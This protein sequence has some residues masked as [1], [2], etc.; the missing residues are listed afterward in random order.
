MSSFKIGDNLF[1]HLLPFFFI[2]NNKI[3]THITNLLVSRFMLCPQQQI[4]FFILSQIIQ[5][6][7][8]YLTPQSKINRNLIL[9]NHRSLIQIMN[10]NRKANFILITNLQNLII[11]FIQI[12]ILQYLTI[13]I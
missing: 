13:I 1:S 5:R 4:Q 9:S 12:N 3:K 2:I 11:I 8:L 7:K 6:P 10:P